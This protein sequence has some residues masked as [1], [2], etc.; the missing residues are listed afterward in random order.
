[1]I[2]TK[3]YIKDKGLAD[4]LLTGSRTKP[5]YLEELLNDFAQE[6]VK[7]LTIPDVV[8]SEAELKAKLEEQ[9]EEIRQ[10]LIGEDFEGLAERL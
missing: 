6:L 4:T 2:D 7:N 1:M 10:W 5:I 3:K 8:F 9:K